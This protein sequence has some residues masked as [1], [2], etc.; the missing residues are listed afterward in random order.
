MQ[1][2]QK[3]SQWEA[4]RTVQMK[5]E[6]PKH[7]HNHLQ[8]NDLETQQ[9]FI[10]IE[11]NHRL[12][13]KPLT[14]NQGSYTVTSAL[15]PAGLLPSPKTSVM[16]ICQTSDPHTFCN[17]PPELQTRV[18]ICSKPVWPKITIGHGFSFTSVTNFLCAPK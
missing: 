18:N 17:T 9:I 8:G 15:P 6:Q 4:N 2:A 13:K 14:N 5:R 7:I 12:Q 3:C 10:T 16:S 11:A 1:K